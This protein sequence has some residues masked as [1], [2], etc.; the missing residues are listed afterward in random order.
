MPFT[1]HKVYFGT[2]LVLRVKHHRLVLP[3]ATAFQTKLLILR[4]ELSEWLAVGFILFTYK[5]FYTT[6]A[7]SM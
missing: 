3:N 5:P 7:K 1:F 6:S 4:V 2:F